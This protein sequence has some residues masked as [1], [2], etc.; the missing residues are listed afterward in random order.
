MNLKSYLFILG[1][2]ATTALRA[3]D[4]ASFAD[5]FIA[6]P[7]L[8]EY[9]ELPGGTTNRNFR[10]CVEGRDYLVREA[11][12]GADLLGSDMA[13]EFETL[14]LISELNIAP[15]PCYF[16]PV[17]SFMVREF[18]YGLATLSDPRTVVDGAALARQLHES[19]VV[20][21]ATFDIYT[22]I[23][24]AADALAEG[25]ESLPSLSHLAEI[26]ERFPQQPA[27]PCHLDLHGGNFIYDGTRTWLVDWEYAAMA[28]PAVD[29]AL[30]ASAEHQNL[31]QMWTL[32]EVYYGKPTAAQ[33]RHL[34]AMRVL[35]DLR[36]GFWCYL[37]DRVSK[38][39]KPFRQWGDD[40][41]VSSRI[42]YKRLQR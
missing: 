18:L 30:F 14:K 33:W 16:D 5:D 32:A 39:H 40:F 31:E 19:S 42:W 4:W 34:C 38:L 9:E 2:I 26:R 1:L 23:Y 35:A 13:I 22:E 41:L 17:R 7:E 15:Q 12:V 10:V 28:D 8:F 27:A 6:H 11:C 25:G 37:Q 20:F 36:W 29:L 3:Q 21:N 24:K